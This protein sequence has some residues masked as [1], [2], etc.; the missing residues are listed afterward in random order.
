M[1]KREGE[2]YES[3]GASTPYFSLI[4]LFWMKAGITRLSKSVS[5]IRSLPLLNIAVVPPP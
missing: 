3:K 5:S 4:R 2:N 1:Y